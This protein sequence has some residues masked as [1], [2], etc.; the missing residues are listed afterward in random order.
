MATSFRPGVR[1]ISKIRVKAIDPNDSTR[2]KSDSLVFRVMSESEEKPSEEEAIQEKLP[3]DFEM[4]VQNPNK[5][6]YAGEDLYLKTTINKLKDFEP[7][8]GSFVYEVRDFV[9]QSID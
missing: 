8:E 2:H 7:W 1:I 4:E 9:R 3:F 5:I 6:V